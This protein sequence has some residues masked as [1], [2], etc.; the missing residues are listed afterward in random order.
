MAPTIDCAVQS[1]GESMPP[2]K[3]VDARNEKQLVGDVRNGFGSKT[4]KVLLKPGQCG[5]EWV[6]QAFVTELTAAG[7]A[8]TC[9]EPG[10]ASPADFVVTGELTELYT[11]LYMTYD[12]NVR[13]TVTV[14][15]GPRL[16]LEKTYQGKHVEPAVVASAQE[17]EKAYAGTL[18]DILKQAVPDIAKSLGSTDRRA[19]G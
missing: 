13:V 5:A 10:Q 11:T 12:P 8:V 19:G 16:L 17:Y 6:T 4:A 2:A 14:R 15:S 1:D 9:K 18:Q 7:L 3:F